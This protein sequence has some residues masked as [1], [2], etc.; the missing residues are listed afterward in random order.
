MSYRRQHCACVWM[1]ARDAGN[2]WWICIAMLELEELSFG[3]MLYLPCFTHNIEK[4]TQ[5]VVVHYV[6]H[7]DEM[8]LNVLIPRYLFTV[9]VKNWGCMFLCSGGAASRLW[10][11][12]SGDACPWASAG[13]SF[14]SG[15][16]SSGCSRGG[17]GDAFWSP[18]RGSCSHDGIMFVMTS[19]SICY[20][21]LTNSANKWILQVVCISDFLRL[22][23]DTQ[24]F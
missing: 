6:G 17:R 19:L 3:L 24:L 10:A 14:V 5:C 9:L 4:N 15:G 20:L 11:V 7:A 22:H 2:D 1:R 21:H 12:F 16:L 18:E 13:G 23:G 8:E